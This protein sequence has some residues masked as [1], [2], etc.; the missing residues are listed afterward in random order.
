MARAKKMR[1]VVPVP[2]RPLTGMS[3]RLTDAHRVRACVTDRLSDYNTQ[4]SR[5][6]AVGAQLEP[7]TSGLLDEASFER[8]GDGF[9]LS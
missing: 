9:K 5:T 3:G 4:T 6:R 2:E 8:G 7:S 1:R